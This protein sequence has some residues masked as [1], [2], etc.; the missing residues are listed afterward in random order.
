[1]QEKIACSHHITNHI[2]GKP[3]YSLKKKF[4]L[5]VI[6]IIVPVLGL[7]FTWISVKLHNQAKQETLEKARVVTDQII[8][9]RQW[10]TDCMGGVF[11]NTQ[12]PGARDVTSATTDRMTTAHGTYQLFTPSMVT[13][14]LSQYSFRE[15]AYYFRLSSLNPLNTANSPDSFEKQALTLFNGTQGSEFYRFTEDAMDYMVPLYKTRGCLQ[16]HTDQ[17]LKT[18]QI[19]GGLRVTVPYKKV[20]ETFKKNLFL[21]GGA[22]L[23]ITLLTIIVLVFLIHTLVLKPL[24]ELEEKSRQLTT[25]DLSSRVSLK[26][27]DELERLGDSFNLMADS[28]MRNRDSL[29]EKVAKAT[30][31]LAQANHELLKLDRLK[32]NFLANMSHELRTP[33]TAAKGSIHYLERTVQNKEDLAYIRIIEKNIS[34]LTRLVANLFD[35]TK[36]EAGK[37]DWEFEREDISQLAAE[38]IEIMGPIAQARQVNL[39]LNAPGPLH[40]VIDLERMEQV[41]VNLL[42]NAIKFSNKNAIVRVEITDQDRHIE[43]RVK[44]QGQGI[45]KESLETVFEKFYTADTLSENR[46]RGAGMGLAIAKAIITAHR[47]EISVESQPKIATTFIVTLPKG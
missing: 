11:V 1:M 30:R 2:P 37:I 8:L 29:E 43:I 32:S 13:K 33:L 40:A 28:L 36:L 3:Y 15:K 45:T 26:T 22:G 31:D 12:S 16:C 10:I 7:L 5:G 35:F 25:G 38:V 18:A 20:R 41:L 46:Q 42:D 17:T 24:N 21:V 27:H 47:G 6:V 23:G 4:V 9:T 19:I 14:K 34:R 44:D 39:Y